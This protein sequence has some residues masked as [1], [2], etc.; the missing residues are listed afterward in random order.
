MVKLGDRVKCVITGVSGILTA[1]T[2]WLY[3]CRRLGIQSERPDK[4][5]KLIDVQW[6]DEAQVVLV[7]AGAVK[8]PTVTAPRQVST[9]GPNRG[10]EIR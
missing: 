10:E 6:F 2:I 9:G 4:D 1:E 8:A 7:K 3:G 5:G